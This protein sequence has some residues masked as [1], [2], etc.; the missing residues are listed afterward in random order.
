MD[1]LAEQYCAAPWFDCCLLTRAVEPIF[2]TL[3]ECAAKNPD[4]GQSDD[5]Q[6]GDFFYDE[7]EV[8]HIPLLS[9]VGHM[10]IARHSPLQNRICNLFHQPSSPLVRIL[11]S[12]MRRTRSN[13]SSEF[14]VE[15]HHS[16]PRLGGCTHML[17]RLRL[18]RRIRAGA[19]RVAKDLGPFRNRLKPCCRCS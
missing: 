11:R 2:A 4:P 14:C 15:P 5:E 18:L 10:C 13:N 1:A 17:T 7:D 16:K 9:A 6:D 8:P 19:K 3:C 12:A